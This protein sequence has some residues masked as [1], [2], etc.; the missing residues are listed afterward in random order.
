[1]THRS[2]RLQRPRRAYS[3]G[4]NLIELMIVVGIA[5][6]LLLISTS[7]YQQ[8][9]QRAHRTEATSA[10]TQLAARQESFRNVHHTYTDDLDA[11]GFPGGCGD[12]DCV[13]TLSFTVT[14]DTRTFTARAEPTPGGG[15]NGVNQTRDEDCAWF[16]IDARGVT[17]AGPGSKC[18]TGG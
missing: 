18:W 13:Y 16:T 15:T 9:A 10:L 8:Y 3:R 14:P 6:L 17:A 12:Q 5:G 7:A 1:M 11:L 4:T 2:A